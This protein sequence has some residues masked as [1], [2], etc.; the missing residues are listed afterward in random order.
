[1]HLAS[2][3][4]GILLTWAVIALFAGIVLGR[5]LAQPGRK[6][7]DPPR[8]Q[9]RSGA[10]DANSAGSVGEP[11]V[12]DNLHHRERAPTLWERNHG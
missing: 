2:T 5:A 1:M 10:P 6:L 8:D 12:V 9:D 7:L 3:I 11:R 4:A